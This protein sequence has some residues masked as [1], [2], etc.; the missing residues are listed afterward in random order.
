[1]KQVKEWIG[2]NRFTS[3]VLVIVLLGLVSLA[4][5][6]ATGVSPLDP[7]QRVTREELGNEV[8]ILEGAARAERA[9]LAAQLEA[10]NAKVDQQNRLIEN[11]YASIEKGEAWRAKVAQF[12]MDSLRAVAS[13]TAPT[14]PAGMLGYLVS[15]M[16]LLGVG[17][18]ADNIRK[19]TVISVQKSTINKIAAGPPPS[20]PPPPVA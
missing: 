7:T 6:A 5:C 1:M 14:T 2:N 15:G 3:V 19:R 12:G 11:S 16:A 9:Q 10:F 17:A 13:G 20:E 4:S 8:A 18:T